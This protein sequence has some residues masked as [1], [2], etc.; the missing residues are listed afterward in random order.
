MQRFA[1]HP[2]ATWRTLEVQLLPYIA[3]LRGSR[4]GALAIRQKLLDTIV[5][6][7]PSPPGEASSFTDNR[8]LSGEFLLGFHSQRQ[9]LRPKKNEPAS[10]EVSS[11]PSEGEDQ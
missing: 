1:D 2:Y 7:F 10:A 5:D 8:R 9:A 6:S 3:R 4:A 11:E